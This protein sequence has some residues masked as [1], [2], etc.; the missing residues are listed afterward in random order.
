M[1]AFPRVPWGRRWI[2][3]NVVART[4]LM[5]VRNPRKKFPLMPRVGNKVWA[6]F[7]RVP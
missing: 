2:G 7:P 5:T 1:S 4:P 6:K 3:E